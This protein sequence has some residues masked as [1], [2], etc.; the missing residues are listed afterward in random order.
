MINVDYSNY[1][2]W[3][4]NVQENKVSFN[5]VKVTQIGYDIRD[6]EDVG[7]EAFTDLLH[8]EDYD[9]TMRAMME[10]LTGKS[11]LYTIDYRIK[12]KD[13]NYSWYMD[14][15]YAVERDDAGKP[16]II[17]GLVID[18]GSSL[19]EKVKQIV[20]ETVRRQFSNDAIIT[21][22]AVCKK[23][24]MDNKEW[25]LLKDNIDELLAGNVSH[26]ICPNCIKTLYRDD[27]TKEE[28]EDLL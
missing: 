14:R 18:L 10:L 13:G 11:N 27:F 22:C 24:K 6:F 12:R 3:E 26:G 4:W 8:S 2:W 21:I 16:K 17:R 28:L 7:Y 23:V 15:G 19:E 25:V 20:Y 9:R 1:P 5:P